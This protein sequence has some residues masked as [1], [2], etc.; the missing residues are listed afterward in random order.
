M[1][2][3][4][5]FI[6]VGI[7]MSLVGLAAMIARKNEAT[8][9]WLGTKLGAEWESGL[10]GMWLGWRLIA[11]GAFLVYFEIAQKGGIRVLTPSS[12]LGTIALATS[13]A[14][15]IACDRPSGQVWLEGKFGKEWKTHFI[16]KFMQKPLFIT[17]LFMWLPDGWWL[18][19]F[20][21]VF[22]V[23]ATWM[24]FVFKDKGII[25][26]KKSTPTGAAPESMQQ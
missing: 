10:A 26:T 8:N 3:V 21:L 17:G 16:V 24:I 4:K 9:R 1:D 13:F 2:M 11:L 18:D 22:A 19:A 7:L 5:V 23:F 20:K 25:G 15:M 12:V 6:L 14:M